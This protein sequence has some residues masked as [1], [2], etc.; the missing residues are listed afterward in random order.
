M[1]FVKSSHDPH[2]PAVNKK[3]CKTLHSYVYIAATVSIHDVIRV[4]KCLKSHKNWNPKLHSCT[5][6][7]NQA[8]VHVDDQVCFHSWL[9]ADRVKPWTCTTGPVEPI[10]GKQGCV[11]CQ[12]KLLLMIIFGLCSDLCVCFCYLMKT[13][14]CCLCP[15]GRYNQPLAAHPPWPPA[16][17][18]I[19]CHW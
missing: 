19:M 3:Y 8:Y 1:L 16:H 15:C 18:F 2:L 13:R 5:I 17:F 12:C 7:G 9:F 10:S 11:Q 4:T 14:N 6:L